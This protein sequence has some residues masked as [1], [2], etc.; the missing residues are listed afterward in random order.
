[1]RG[2]I[3]IGA[4]GGAGETIVTSAHTGQ[5][6]PSAGG[7][8][9]GTLTGGAGGTAA[10][11]LGRLVPGSATASLDHI[12][13]P[14]A[15]STAI[16]IHPFSGGASHLTTSANLAR[17]PGSPTVGGPDGLFVAP[18][19]QIDSL[20]ASG[21]SRTEIE[22]ALGLNQGA[23]SSGDLLR[24]DITDPF[25]RNL[26]LPDPKLGNIHHRPGTGLTT[27]NYNEAIIDSPAKADPAVIFT[28]LGVR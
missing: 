25:Q 2:A 12:P 28:N 19:P 11:G 1:M 14:P 9:F 16:E 4:A 15:H 8:V 3:T 10:H 23:L 13:T 21:A 24:V 6:M 5:G 18:T 27:G 7:L 17:F 20:A 22:V 26:R